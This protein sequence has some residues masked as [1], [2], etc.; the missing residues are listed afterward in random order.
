MV[1]RFPMK[2]GVSGVITDLLRIFGIP[3]NYKLLSWEIIQFPGILRSGFVKI[4]VPWGI[5]MTIGASGVL[6]E[7][8]PRDA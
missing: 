3:R 1:L 7:T 5:G 6:D 8:I 2:S 4:V